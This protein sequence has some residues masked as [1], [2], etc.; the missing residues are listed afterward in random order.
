VASEQSSTPLDV[1]NLSPSPQSFAFGDVTGDGR[2]DLVVAS[3]SSLALF[4]ERADGRFFP[5]I[6]LLCDSLTC[7]RGAA[8]NSVAIADVDG[9][10]LKEI[11]AARGAGS[12]S[13]IFG[14]GKGGFPAQIQLASIGQSLGA[15]HVA[16]IDDDGDND[17]LVTDIQRSLAIVLQNDGQAG[18]SIGNLA[19]DVQPVRI[20]AA[21]AN[22]DGTMDLVT[23]NRRFDTVSVLLGLGKGAF[24]AAASF[25][26]GADPVDLAAADLNG[27][28]PA[29]V[30]TA[31]SATDDCTVL[32]TDPDGIF[33]HNPCLG[34]G[35][36]QG[37]IAAQARD[38]NR[39]Q[40]PDVVFADY[41]RERLFVSRGRGD[42]RFADGQPYAVSAYT[43]H[44][45][46]GDLNLDRFP[47][48]LIASSPPAND[49]QVDSTDLLRSDGAGGFLPKVQIASAVGRGGIAVG[50]LN[51]DGRPD[52]ATAGRD[53]LTLFAGNGRGSFTPLGNPLALPTGAEPRSIDAGDV[54]RDGW[55]DLVTANRTTRNVSLFFG[56]GRGSFAARRDYPLAGGPWAAVVADATGD[57][58][59]DIV[60][61]ADA[62]PSAMEPGVVVL[63]V[64][65]GRR[66][67]T[68]A[69][70]PAGIQPQR[71]LARDVTGDAIADLVTANRQSSTISL[72]E[73]IGGGEFAPP[74]TFRVGDTPSDLDLP[75]LDGDGRPDTL[76]ANLNGHD[77]SILLNQSALPFVFGDL[78]GNAT[79]E[80]ADLLRL[81][82]E[83][84]DG[85]GDLAELAHE[86]WTMLDAR[87]D[88][89]RDGRVSAADLVRI[90]RAL[91]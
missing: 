9:D 41:Y 45:V 14:D 37:P 29:E 80:A 70:L 78:N 27:D 79:V 5:N 84:F 85:D 21:D 76:T 88:A 17:V 31:N 59:A 50:D 61:S 8:P 39:D 35:Q 77:C 40:L 54:D 69:T 32:R 48:L 68:V 47:D 13:V 60:V 15:V 36:S 2:D 82:P 46:I 87:A 65:D 44:L 20:V 90:V 64:G 51:R 58:I 3:T 72:L 56:N 55:L 34:D 71:T 1:S 6:T 38:L 25:E 63:L 26:V 23:A 28:G 42:F 57:A 30:V 10:G 33:A 86:G 89:N 12:I 91:E 62:G 24:A 43:R 49:S 83:L 7:P 11:V 22:G 4:V 73:G 75:D 67:F 74:V 81:T 18:F 52:I 16:D 53:S 66:G 19:V